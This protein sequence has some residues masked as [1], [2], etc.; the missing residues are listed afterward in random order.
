MASP[1]LSIL[2]I[3]T[4]FQ[5][6]LLFSILLLLKIFLNYLIIYNNFYLPPSIFQYL[7]IFLY[8]C[9]KTL[10][11]YHL[12]NVLTIIQITLFLINSKLYSLLFLINYFFF[13]FLNGIIIFIFGNF[14]LFFRTKKNSILNF[15]FPKLIF[16]LF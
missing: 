16:F 14:Y 10:F 4:T 5:N 2:P 11:L 13:F 7:S 3:Q 15:L 8:T 12:K 6:S 1:F 9:L